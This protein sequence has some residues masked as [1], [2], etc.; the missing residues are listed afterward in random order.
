MKSRVL[1][2]LSVLLMTASTFAGTLAITNAGFETDSAPVVGATGWTITS[3]G[4]DWFTTTTGMPDSSVDPAAAAEGE[5]WLSGNRLVAGAGSS[6]NPQ[7]IVQLVDISADAALVDLGTATVILDFMFADND[8]YDT[9]TVN[10]TFFSDV[11][12]TT[13]IGT[14]LS[15][16]AMAPT[17]PEAGSTARAPWEARSLSGAVPAL[18]R[19]LEIEIVNVR[20]NGSAG[21][22][23]FDAFSGSIVPEP[24]TLA[25]LGLGALLI[26]RKR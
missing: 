14:S 17:G 1:I 25:I 22:T 6:S 3:G 15:T 2:V 20:S 13:L 18:A 4:T 16:G 19:A 26:R 23:H 7:N 10:I 11:A 21:N 24:A 8:S 12:G 9:G 5:N